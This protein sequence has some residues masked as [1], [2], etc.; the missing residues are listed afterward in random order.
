[1]AS[2][3]SFEVGRRGALEIEVLDEMRHAGEA[4][5]FEARTAAETSTPG[6]PRAA[7]ASTP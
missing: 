2:A 4:I 7:A 3:I 5:V 1:M 6:S